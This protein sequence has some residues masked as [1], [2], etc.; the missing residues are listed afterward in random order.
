MRRSWMM[1]AVGLLVAVFAIGAVACDDDEDNGGGE[2]TATT[3]DGAGA[4]TATAEPGGEEPAATE[5]PADGAGATLVVT[6]GIL[7]TTDGFTVYTFDNDE[8]GVSNC[9]EGCVETWPPLPVA[10]E[11]TA[12]EGVSGAVG[13]ITRDDGTTQVTYDDQPLYLYS[14]DASPGE[15]NGDGVAG[16]WHVV[17]IN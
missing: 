10:G 3:E 4:A 7:T 1:I 13:T 6:N 15:T 17:T 9:G 14:G 11:P 5:E 12:G 8:P 2:P 16:I